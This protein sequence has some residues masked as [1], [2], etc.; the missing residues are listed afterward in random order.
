MDADILPV[1]LAYLAAY[2]VEMFNDLLKDANKMAER[3]VTLGARTE[4]LAQAIPTLEQFISET[5]PYVFLE[6]PRSNFRTRKDPSGGQLFTSQSLPSSLQDVY[7]RECI[8]PPKLA[9]LNYLREDGRD[10]MREY[11]NPTFFIDEWVAEQ[12]RQADEAKAKR[13]ADRAG[14]GAARKDRQQKQIKTAKLNRAKY[15]PQGLGLRPEPKAASPRPDAPLPDES[16]PEPPSALS[17]SVSNYPSGGNA[18]SQPPAF[19]PRPAFENAPVQVHVTPPAPARG[20]GHLQSVYETSPSQGYSVYQVPSS[21]TPAAPAAAAPFPPPP[22][23]SAGFSLPPGAAPPSPRPASE[24]PAP[25]PRGA[26]APPPAPSRGG[27][28]PPPPGPGLAPRPNAPPAAPPSND[29]E[30][31]EEGYDAATPT[32]G[33][34]PPPPPGPKAPAPPPPPGPRA[35]PP[36]RAPAAVAAA[37]VNVRSNLMQQIQQGKRLKPVEQEEEAPKPASGGGGGKADGFNVEKILARRNALADSDS[38]SEDDNE[39]D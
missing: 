12:K 22:P 31:G 4:A 30:G 39:W 10:C 26:P 13:A 25:S 8:P 17:N 14:K 24:R 19:S 34:P 15:D 20:A 28:P 6:N 35:P 3:I 38:E 16:L 32:G 2:S 33:P 37:P 23:P 11:S 18:F 29:E 1:Q 7:N 36:P 21:A 27:P 5:N 9:I